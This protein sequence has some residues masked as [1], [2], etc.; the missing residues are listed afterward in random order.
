MLAKTLFFSLSPLNKGRVN[1]TESW[2]LI[3]LQLT[4]KIVVYFSPSLIKML[5]K[6]G[7]QTVSVRLENMAQFRVTETVKS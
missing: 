6:R 3:M 5:E 7:A 4:T 2:L 1:D